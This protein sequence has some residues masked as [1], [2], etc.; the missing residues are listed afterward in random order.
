MP[1][2][3]ALLALLLCLAGLPHAGAARAAE[4][5]VL[6]GSRSASIDLTLTRTTTF[7]VGRPEPGRAISAR[8]GG[9][10][11]GVVVSRLDGSVVVGA[12]VAAGFRSGGAPVPMVFGQ[13]FESVRVPAGR[14]R[15][16]LLANGAGTEVR[17]PA[18]GVGRVRVLAPS[19][20]VDVHGDVVTRRTPV[21]V[22]IGEVRVPL[23]TGSR[24][25]VIL[26]TMQSY[27][28]TAASLDEVCLARSGSTCRTGSVTG[29]STVLLGGAGRA[30]TVSAYFAYP[31][32][33]PAGDYD[34]IFVSGGAGVSEAL[35]AFALRIG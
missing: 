22:P 28:V 14:Y 33:T 20:R 19:T 17:I 26:A 8:I 11:A 23:R 21:G 13:G 34:A 25:T 35:S 1:R 32:D 24:S 5:V 30:E 3:A 15:I 2:R 18:I 12:V 16:T 6:R 4:A 9:T 29:G 10:F 7:E 27:A 31:G